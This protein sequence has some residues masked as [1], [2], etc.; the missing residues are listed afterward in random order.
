MSSPSFE[1]MRLQSHSK[2]KRQMT[3]HEQQLR[4][5][6][7]KIDRQKTCLYNA[8]SA[9]LRCAVNPMRPCTTCT[10]YQPSPVKTDHRNPVLDSL[11]PQN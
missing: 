2:I 5:I 7:Q 1:R 9:F 6:S 3:F 11:P 4:L 10:H 8:H